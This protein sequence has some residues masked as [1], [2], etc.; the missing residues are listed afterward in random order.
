MDDYLTKPL[1]KQELFA[2]LKRVSQHDPSDPAAARA[3]TP[4]KPEFDPRS[5]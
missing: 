3:N 2:L 4:A 5:F 1:N